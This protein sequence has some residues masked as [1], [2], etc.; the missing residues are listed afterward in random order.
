MFLKRKQFVSQFT[1]QQALQYKHI[2]QYTK[3]DF[4]PDSEF[5]CPKHI[6]GV[7]WTVMHITSNSKEVVVGYIEDDVFYVV[8]LDKEHLFW[9]SS[10]KNT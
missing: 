3:V 1:V 5:V 6:F 2:K 8:F 9:P 4:P 7:V 10:K